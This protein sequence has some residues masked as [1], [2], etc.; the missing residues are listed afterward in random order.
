MADVVIPEGYGLAKLTWSMSGKS[1]PITSTC[2]YVA[3][4]TPPED[5]AEAIYGYA[6]MDGSI[7][8]PFAMS[9]TYTFENV[10]VIQTVD[11]V[12]VGAAFGTPITGAFTVALPPVNGSLLV[13]KKTSRVGRQFQGRFYLPNSHVS[14]TLIDPMGN[15]DSTSFTGFQSRVDVFALGTGPSD[16]GFI[17]NTI[18]NAVILHTDPALT[19]TVITSFL[20]RQQLATQR[21]RMRS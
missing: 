11:G 1:N 6:T 3:G 15:L 5:C 10:E 21:R 14:E 4:L 16:L 12:P 7:A 17:S 18:V 2:G 13:S 20:P 19:P 8:D 9:T